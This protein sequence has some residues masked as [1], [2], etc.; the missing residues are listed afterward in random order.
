MA[1]PE[2]SEF[3]YL[4][5][6]EV[7]S[8]EV[9]GAAHDEGWLGSGRLGSENA[10]SSPLQGA[11]EKLAVIIRH[12]HYEDDGCLEED[13]D[14]PRLRLAGVVLLR[15]DAMPFGMDGTYEQACRRLNVEPRPEGWAVWNTWAE[16]KP[17]AFVMTEFDTTEGLLMNWSRGIETYPVTPLPSQI[18]FVYSTWVMPMLLSP[19]LRRRSGADGLPLDG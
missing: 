5:E 2:L 7:L 11:I 17:A 1:R 8:R 3:E 10:P 4:R 15:P 19:A 13:S 18:A 16:G 14:R 12:Y 9:V 6:V